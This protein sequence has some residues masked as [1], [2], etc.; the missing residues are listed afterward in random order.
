MDNILSDALYLCPNNPGPIMHV[1]KQILTHVVNF[2]S[3]AYY[4]K[5]EDQLIALFKNAHYDGEMETM[6][7]LAETLLPFKVYH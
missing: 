3:S 7:A 5:I 1:I 6:K 4:H 2:N